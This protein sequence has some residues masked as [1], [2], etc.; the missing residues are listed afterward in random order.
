MRAHWPLKATLALIAALLPAGCYSPSLVDGFDCNPDHSQ[1]L[2]PS[3]FMCAADNKCY[4]NG[5]PDID[6]GIP[7]VDAG[8]V[9]DG[10]VATPPIMLGRGSKVGIAR[11]STGA[12]VAWLEPS[13]TAASAVRYTD[14][15]TTGGHNALQMYVTSNLPRLTHPGCPSCRTGGSGHPC[16]N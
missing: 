5:P 7:M 12:R 6:G 4:K 8:P 13:L 3:G 16:L 2:C 11:T 14:I 9:V 1:P 15:G 10:A